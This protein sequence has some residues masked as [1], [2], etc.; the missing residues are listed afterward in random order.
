MDADDAEAQTVRDAEMA[1]SPP[2]VL[3]LLLVP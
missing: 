1:P 3:L 2:L